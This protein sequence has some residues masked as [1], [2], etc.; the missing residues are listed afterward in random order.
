MY[1]RTW[2][3]V[4][5]DW[6]YTYIYKDMYEIVVPRNKLL[7]TFTVFFVSSI[8]HDYIIVVAFRFFYPLFL[9]V[10]GGSGLIFFSNISNI[11]MWMIFCIG[12]SI[13]VSLFAIEYYARYNCSSYSDYYADL[14]LPRSWNCQR[15][16]VL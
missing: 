5:H 8:C 2:N 10:F 11:I 9:I 13:V 1:H 12:N 14:L 4:V 3:V 16:L 6:L 7:A 15:Q